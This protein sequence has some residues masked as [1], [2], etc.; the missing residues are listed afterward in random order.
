MTRLFVLGA[1]GGTGR[2]VVG[3]ALA[4]GHRVTAFVR[5]PDKL[6]ARDNLTVVRGDPRRSDELRAALVDHDAAISTL[7]PIGLGRTTIV[8]DGARATVAAMLAAGVRRLVIVGMGARFA[9]GP[10]TALLRGTFL[11]EIARDSAEMERVVM[12]SALDWTIARP[13]RLTDAAFTGAYRVEV[14]RMPSRRWSPALATL[15]RADLAGY[16]L[17]EVERGTHARQIVGVAS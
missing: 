17:D 12:A 10:L 6:G 16:L 1:T 9:Q 15:G 4:R 7:G 11:R 3:Q 5:S 14:D 8:A 13:P 2:A